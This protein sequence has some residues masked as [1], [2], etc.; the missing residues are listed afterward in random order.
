MNAKALAAYAVICGRTLARAH[1]RAGDAVAIAGYLGRGELFDRALAT[2]AET[3]AEQNE[4]DY[5]E[6]SAAVADGRITAQ[7]GV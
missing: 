7:T 3:Y 5:A 4:R 1:A 2:F 6:M